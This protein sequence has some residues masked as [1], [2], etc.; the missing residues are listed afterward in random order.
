MTMINDAGRFLDQWSVQAAA[1][2]WSTYDLFGAHPAAPWQRVEATGLLPLI[3]G[4]TVEA[5]TGDSATLRLSS[6]LRQRY[7]RRGS[8]GAI[9]IWSISESPERQTALPQQA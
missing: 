6:G 4:A 1:L 3:N 2:G 5:I 9:E 7:F 8:P